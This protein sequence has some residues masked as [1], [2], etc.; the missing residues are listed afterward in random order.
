MKVRELEADAL[1]QP[2]LPLYKITPKPGAKNGNSVLR[3]PFRHSHPSQRG[4]H[5]C[6]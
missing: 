5:D 3:A 2:L 1:Q 4:G 6:L